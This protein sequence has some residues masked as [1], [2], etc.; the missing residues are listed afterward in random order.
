M[1]GEYVKG[2]LVLDDERKRTEG[3]SVTARELVA[4]SA[5]GAI[6]ISGVGKGAIWVVDGETV[7]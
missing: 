2:R 7:G 4:D 3:S 1:P 6:Y 5:T